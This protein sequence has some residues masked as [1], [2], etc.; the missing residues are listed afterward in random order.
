MTTVRHPVRPLRRM[1]ITPE[2]IRAFKEME[3][4][5]GRCT[6]TP[7]KEGDCAAC[8]QW[9]SAHSVLHSALGLRP[10]QW[11]A[12]EYPDAVCPYPDGCEAAKHWQ[13]RRDERPEAFELYAALTE[14]AKHSG[15]SAPQRS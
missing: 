8:E 13:R 10:W 9:W 7:G 2:I 14:A 15:L 1:R 12:F 4:T 6:C 11:P 5:R 3:S